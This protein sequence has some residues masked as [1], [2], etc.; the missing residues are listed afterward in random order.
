MEPPEPPRQAGIWRRILA[1][2]R[3]FRLNLVALVTL[4]LV[5]AP[6]GLLT[7]LPLQLVVDSALGHKPPPTWL[8]WLWPP[9]RSANPATILALA[10][11]LVFAIAV[12]AGVHR[13]TEA[14]LRDFTAERIVYAFRSKLF[15]HLQRLS[16]LRHDARG[17]GQAIF[18]MEHDA[19]GLHWLVIYVLLPMISA[20]A[21]LIATVITTALINAK[22]ALV[23]ITVSPLLIILMHVS[24]RGLKS[25]W[26]RVHE[27]ESHAFSVVT[28]TLSALR[29]VRLF[30][31]EQREVARFDARNTQTLKTRLS[32]ALSESV[33]GALVALVVAIGTLVV[34]VIGALDVQAGELTLGELLLLMAYLAQLYAPLETMG[35]QITTQ[36]KALTNV[37]RAF[38]LLDEP[39]SPPD[40]PLAPARG[41]CRGAISFRGVE[42]AYATAVPTLTGINLE[43]AAGDRIGIIGRTGAGK[44]SL[45]ALAA[46]LHDPTAGSVLLDGIDLRQ[47]RLQDL[48]RQFAVVAQDTS[49]FSDTVATN[50]A[51]ARPDAP[52]Q[53]IE[54]AASLAGAH[55][56]ISALPNGYATLCGEHGQRFS[57]GER[58][59][60]A[61]ARAFLTDAPVLIL[62]EPTSAVD[63]A[64]EAAILSGIERLMPGRTTLLITHRLAALAHCRLVVVVE[65][66]RIAEITDDV[67]GIITRYS[68]GDKPKPS[69]E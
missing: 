22:I 36:Q 46:R 21:T 25:R 44:S 54:T 50:I 67:A 55:G 3:P 20:A 5:S 40:N 26:H 52:M 53:D 11:G 14:V 62:D 30:G 64:T 28:E 17:T 27:H 24:R 7:P 31:Q 10:A 56:F 65:Q 35:N 6:L 38:L 61:L 19:G 32:A 39:A 12:I 33:V 57:G 63:Q 2:I 51:Y 13:V 59:R 16:L 58:Q 49:L 69:S 42:F 1:E 37:E 43:I 29:I 66:G 47:W 60:I 45:I 68:I 23:A 9:A 48:R 8:T 15:L 18:S 34:L 41:R 4:A